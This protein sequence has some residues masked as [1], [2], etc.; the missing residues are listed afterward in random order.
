M[1]ACIL[2]NHVQASHP[3]KRRCEMTL[4]NTSIDYRLHMHKSSS[5]RTTHK[6]RCSRSVTLGAGVA[7]GLSELNYICGIK[8]LCCGSSYHIFVC[9]EQ[10][11]AIVH[12]HRQAH[13]P[14]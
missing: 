4:Q 2:D 11:E 6:H 10:N 8:L 12:L 3:R 1:E 7:P 14:L 9:L 5:H 13:E